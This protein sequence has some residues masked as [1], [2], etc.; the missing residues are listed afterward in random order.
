MRSLHGRCKWQPW[1]CN[2]VSP[3]AGIKNPSRERNSYKLIWY[4]RNKIIN[5]FLNITHS[6]EMEEHMRPRK[7][8]DLIKTAPPL[9]W[10]LKN[11]RGQKKKNEGKTLIMTT[12]QRKDWAFHGI[13]STSRPR[14]LAV[15]V[16]N[17]A[18][19]WFYYNLVWWCFLRAL[20]ISRHWK[21][22][23]LL[24]M[25]KRFLNSRILGDHS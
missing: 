22:Y 8:N 14:V 17:T 7:I 10:R 23:C 24:F 19:K 1:K 16:I 12:C 3:S 2:V 20:K 11:L 18:H 13:T 25:K 21:Y 6:K 4:A 15:W 5:F 9:L